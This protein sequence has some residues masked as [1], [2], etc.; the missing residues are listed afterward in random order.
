ME[1]LFGNFWRLLG[2]FL[3]WHLVTVVYAA[4]DS[5]WKSRDSCWT[6]L[7]RRRPPSSDSVRWCVNTVWQ[8][9]TKL[10]TNAEKCG[11]KICPASD[12]NSLHRRQVRSLPLTRHHPGADR[13]WPWQL[14]NIHFRASYNP[15]NA[16]EHFVPIHGGPPIFVRLLNKAIYA[17]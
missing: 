1:I 7:W 12:G 5:K 17:R 2:Y 13:R 14:L 6:F 11:R 10:Q 15:A 4:N 3:P 9:T 16:L 8:E